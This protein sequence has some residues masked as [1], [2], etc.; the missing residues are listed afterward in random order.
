MAKQRTVSPDT[1]RKYRVNYNYLKSIGANV[2]PNFEDYTL[3][4]QRNL[5]ARERKEV[6]KLVKSQGIEE[7]YE[8]RNDL[9]VPDAYKTRNGKI[10]ERYLDVYRDVPNIELELAYLE[11]DQM[12]RYYR[13]IDVSRRLF[14][15]VKQYI[16]QAFDT[17]KFEPKL[18]QCGV[19]L[20][21][22]NLTTGETRRRWKHS[23]LSTIGDALTNLQ[24]KLDAEKE[25]PIEGSDWIIV[26]VEKC[27]IHLSEGRTN[28]A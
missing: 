15:N 24:N 10:L 8:T 7:L 6:V 11:L 17:R 18:E 9:V 27:K 19:Y 2:K 22:E 16:V 21:E 12:L 1:L 13:N 4:G 20:Y 3:S 25:N 14:G 5:V 28:A 26:H 23:N